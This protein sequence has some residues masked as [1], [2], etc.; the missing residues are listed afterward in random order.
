M[1]DSRK[2]TIR[3]LLFI[4]AF[5]SISRAFFSSSF[6]LLRGSKVTL[7]AINTGLIGVG[8]LLIMR[9]KEMITGITVSNKTGDIIYGVSRTA[10]WKALKL[11][12]FSRLLMP[13][14]FLFLPSMGLSFL[15]SSGLLSTGILAVKMAEMALCLIS[16]CVAIP[17]S[18]ALFN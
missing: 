14:P 9:S 13:L 3:R 12:A 10:A 7:N 15:Q 5:A 4:L 6:S 17:S 8:N 18:L 16:A 2:G 11:S 1:N